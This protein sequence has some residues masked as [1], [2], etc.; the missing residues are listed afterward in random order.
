M[1]ND[2]NTLILEKKANFYKNEKL[3]VHITLKDGKFYNATI[4]ELSAD[5]IVVWDRKLGKMPVFFSEI[6]SI[7]P[8]EVLDK[9]GIKW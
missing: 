1:T 3:L 2:T 8:Y 9:R 7:E 5:F 6:D 4:K